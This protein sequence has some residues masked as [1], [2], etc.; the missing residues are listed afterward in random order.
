M[1]Q[2][3]RRLRTGGAA[4]ESFV[5][6]PDGSTAPVASATPSNHPTVIMQI[7]VLLCLFILW[8]LSALNAGKTYHRKGWMS[9]I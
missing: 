5:T 2:I 6:V 7:R 4:V 8:F 3:T 1:L 9:G